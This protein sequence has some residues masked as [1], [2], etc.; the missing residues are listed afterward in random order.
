MTTN[1][2]GEQLVRRYLRAVAR[3]L[4]ARQ[5]AD[6][7]REI[8]T[9]VEDKLEERT[10]GAAATQGAVEDVLR[11]L[12]DP[13]EVARRFDPHPCHL[14]G[15]ELF[16]MFARI[17]KII[18]AGAAGIALLATYLP[19]LVAV[20]PAEAWLSLGS[21]GHAL[22]LYY[23]LVLALFAH[24][25]V[26]FYLLERFHVRLTGLSEPF[27][28]RSLP[29]LPE[30]EGD[31]MSYVD[32]AGRVGS[33]AVLAVVVNLA[34][35]LLAFPAG[36][37]RSGLGLSDLGI[38]LPLTLINAWILLGVGLTIIVRS[39]GRW[40]AWLRALDLAVGLFGVWV[41]YNLATGSV[42]HAPASVP[43]LEPLARLLGGLLPYA[44]VLALVGWGL[45][46]WKVVHRYVGRKEATSLDGDG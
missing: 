34:P 15:P 24:L 17:T 37:G 25:V 33:L 10:G 29:E 44:P 20:G 13:R 5:R 23:Q 32:F 35:G 40:T 4:P 28:P 45:G 11:E 19:R 43:R 1:H 16:P 36:A 46:V 12:G 14:V 9:L 30:V 22:G 6:V 18:L 2:A 21:L 39:A 3:A 38:V 27:D 26:T 42:V 8:G 41:V 7:C 31:E